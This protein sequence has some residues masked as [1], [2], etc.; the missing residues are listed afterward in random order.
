MENLLAFAAPPLVLIVGI[1]AAY[2]RPAPRAE[3][4]TL[5]IT[6]RKRSWNAAGQVEQAV[7]RLR[8]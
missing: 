5:R 3:F 6:R 7:E 2:R 1:L 8:G 4:G